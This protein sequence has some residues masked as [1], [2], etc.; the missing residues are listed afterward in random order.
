MRVVGCFA[1][2]CF[3]VSL[4]N[5]G[6][7]QQHLFVP[8]P[9]FQIEI[10]STLS[11]DLCLAPTRT[12]IY[13]SKPDL[14][15]ETPPSRP[16]VAAK[17]KGN[18]QPGNGKGNE[19]GKRTHQKRRRK[20][21]ARRLPLS[22]SEKAAASKRRRRRE[23]YEELRAA[24][25]ADA[26]APPSVWS[27]DALFPAPVLD[28]ESV[29]EDLYGGREREEE[30]RA[31]RA[32]LS[33]SREEE[34][35]RTASERPSRPEGADTKAE[36]EAEAKE[37]DLELTRRAIMR[38]VAETGSADE[39]RQ[40]Q[41]QPQPQQ[42]Q[43]QQPEPT[44][45]RTLTRMVEDRIY[46]LTRSPAGSIQY[47]TSLLDTSRAVQFREGVRLGKA[48]PVNID[49]LCYFAKKDLRAGRRE[50]AQEHYTEARRMDPT[51]GRP[52]LG[53]SR[54][55]ERRGDLE[56]ARALLKEGIAKST[57][58]HVEVRGPGT[59]AVV[60]GR[61][62]RTG[63]NGK[64]LKSAVDF[65]E[66]DGAVA[67]TIPDAGPN[68][69]LLQALG[70]LEQK[71]GNVSAAEELY[72]QAVRSRP[73]HAAAWVALAQLRT[74]ELR[75]G[76]AEG[77]ACYRSA[78]RE[79]QR[80]GARPN[81]YVYTA[82]ASLE[83]RKGGGDDAEGVKRARELYRKALGADPHCSVAYL[84]LGVMESRAG[85]CD[86]ARECFEEVLQFDQ[87]NSR[88]LQAYAIME[89]RR[90]DANSRKVL[91]LFER[92]LKA[93]PRDAGVYQAY[94]LYVVELGDVDVAR[95]LLRRGTEV[96]K[97]HAPAWQAWGVLE[98]RF[99]TAK[100][101]RDVFQQGIWACAQ[102][103]GGQSGGR[104]CA[105]L[106]QAWG[107]LEAREGDHAAARRCF[108]RALD[109]DQRNVAAV[110]AWTSMEAKLGNFVDARSIY[111][112]SL[113]LFR[114]PSAD[115][116]AVWRAY[117]VME[118]RAGNT[119]EAQLVFQRSMG[120]SMALSTGGGDEM[121]SDAAV[122]P[123]DL[124]STSPPRSKSERRSKEVEF[125]RWDTGSNELDAEVWMN[126]GS[127]EGKVP[128]RQMKKYKNRR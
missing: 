8:R 72:L 49:K 77:R 124:L 67:G 101:A 44:V 100:I 85:N 37:E 50:E 98:T 17:N 36:A 80:V 88:V 18:G 32:A 1:A 115:K 127:I 60:E 24:S 99:G 94:A 78:E 103:G 15:V 71:L 113:K 12:A 3:E 16:S 63:K 31:R 45:D 70:T 65:E 54:I 30:M 128:P 11:R 102:P 114:S 64:S 52:Y 79:L 91:D 33:R 41:E 21:Y 106:W 73:S 92:A 38:H 107:V 126:D 10:P 47:S 75:R 108:S 86:R 27:F 123:S 29:R 76:A 87:R 5:E 83:H 82:W 7:F 116:T 4:W 14:S 43:Q 121:V 26:G 23:A 39:D 46:G 96:D 51:D 19:S 53:L 22:P 61:A 28:E 35:R 55:A 9:P 111:E 2:L 95:D 110:T 48:L 119:R 59:V 93:N 118:E 105:R 57:G 34:E 6:L 104:R 42:Q 13:M 109:A 97:R 117:E 89:S 25:L 120:E 74:K 40:P 69:F 90:P 20:R 56:S 112:R 58:G 84:Q 68:P 125:S 81:A 66:E 62:G 122:V